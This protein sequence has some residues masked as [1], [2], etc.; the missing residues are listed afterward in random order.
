MNYHKTFSLSLQKKFEKRNLGLDFEVNKAF[1]ELRIK[2][3]LHRC[4]IVK[5]KGY[6]T[7][8]LLYMI[9]LLPFL[10][11]Y[12]SYFWNAKC[13]SQ[14]I[15]AQKDTYYRFLNCERFNW[16]KF[17]YFLA[18][19]VIATCD[20]APL[21][22]RILIA[23]DTIAPKSGKNMELVSYHFDHTTQRSIL[24]NQCLQLGY[25]NG[26]HF[27]PVDMAFH[28]SNS[29]PN[30]RIRDIDKRSNGWLR[31]KEAFRK[32]TDVLIEMIDRAWRSGI[33]ASFVLFD[34][35]FA[36]D[37]VISQ[38]YAIG[39]GVIC[40]LKRGRVKYAYQGQNYT[41]KQ[42]W[43]VAKNNTQWLGKFQ[44]KA[45]F[46]NV[47]LP[48]TG[49]VR[50]LFISDG[51]KEWQAFLCTDLQLESAEILT[52]YARRWAIEIFFKDA[53]QM[54]YLGKEQSNTFDAAVTCY[55]LVMIRYLL[56]VYILNRYE[57]TGV[58]P[59]FRDI[60]DS[61]LQLCFAEKIWNHIKELMITSSDLI[62]HKIDS[63]IMLHLLDIVEE[64]IV[65]QIQTLPAKL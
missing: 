10:K 46:L 41:L 25:H 21:S 22:E 39:Y 59:L 63:D 30:N 12:L 32:K 49:D 55:S 33:D 57:F 5:Q 16:R 52:Y 35:W 58:G 14:Q 7:A 11:K 54:L 9:I 40:R 47:T 26:T 48:K 38:I 42:L 13:F 15:D 8:T 29:R 19:R 6:A 24:G 4:H 17:L 60:S 37:S 61:H 53:K 2:S 43:Q 44:V 36:H 23:D 20:E 56:L 18:L 3:L 65:N 51:K 28:T 62:C 27:F 1:N 45:V 50:I 31:R 34:S 64:A